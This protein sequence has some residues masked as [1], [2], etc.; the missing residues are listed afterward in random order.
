M[1]DEL[2]ELASESSFTVDVR[3]T[4]YQH[5]KGEAGG[6][7]VGTWLT[8]FGNL[9]IQ[10]YRERDDGL[11]LVG[12]ARLRKHE[13]WWRGGVEEEGRFWYLAGRAGSSR[14]VF[15]DRGTDADAEVEREGGAAF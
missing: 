13:G 7:T 6:L 5:G 14:L 9:V 3:Q 12:E 11:H 8:T 2:H 10:L 15:F 4:R 1:S